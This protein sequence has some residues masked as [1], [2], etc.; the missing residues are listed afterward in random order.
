MNKTKFH[1]RLCSWRREI[2][3]F[4]RIEIFFPKKF[5]FWSNELKLWLRLSFE[6]IGFLW[7]LN[8]WFVTCCEFYE[9]RAK[10]CQLFHVFVVDA[11][12]AG[13]Q[14][15]NFFSFFSSNI[16]HF[17]TFLWTLI[18]SLLLP[19]SKYVR[20]GVQ[21]S[22]KRQV[23]SLLIIEAWWWEGQCYMS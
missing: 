12:F 15:F 17:K 7:N 11:I 5:L 20:I 16:L 9:F 21:P 18:S 1:S 13:L 14:F 4:S 23:C 10:N 22:L 2:K 8:L 19:K 3:W 6:R